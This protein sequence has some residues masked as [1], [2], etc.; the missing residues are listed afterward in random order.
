[1][2]LF[3]F[4][5]YNKNALITYLQGDFWYKIVSSLYLDGSKIKKYEHLLKL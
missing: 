4:F 1:M 3:Y 5:Y 2:C